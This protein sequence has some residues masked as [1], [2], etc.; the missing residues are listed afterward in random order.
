M[1]MGRVRAQQF[2]PFTA[3]LTALV[4]SVSKY[5]QQECKKVAM[6][7]H[8]KSWNGVPTP[9]TPLKMMDNAQGDVT[10]QLGYSTGIMQTMMSQYRNNAVRS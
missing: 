10:I 7:T 8:N 1:L 5:F 9:L 2:N 4:Q 3:E 6:G